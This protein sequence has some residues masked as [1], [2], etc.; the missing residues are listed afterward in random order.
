VGEV[1]GRALSFCD[2][3]SVQILV[4]ASS[5]D[6]EKRWNL[7]PFDRIVLLVRDDPASSVRLAILLG[8]GGP[9]YLSGRDVVPSAAGQVRDEGSDDSNLEAGE[10]S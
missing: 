9:S 7:F 3:R 2:R 10:S 4:K 6:V 5:S 8:D 1:L